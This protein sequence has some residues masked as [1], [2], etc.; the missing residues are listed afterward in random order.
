MSETLTVPLGE[1]EHLKEFFEVLNDQSKEQESIELSALL[2]QLNQMEKQ[3]TE[4]L[5]EL[6]TVKGQLSNIQEKGIK[7]SAMNG[8]LKLQEKVTEAK[9]QLEHIKS[10]ISNSVK[11]S[12]SLIKQHGISALN[13]TVDFIRLKKV[14]TNMR[15]N[16]NASISQTQKHVD[17]INAIGS[18]I[19]ALSE[20]TNNLG[21]VLTGKETKEL[22]QRNADKGTLAIVAKLLKRSKSMLEGMKQNVTHAI[23]MVDR[24]EQAASKSKEKKPSIRTELKEKSQKE[25]TKK[26]PVVTKKQDMSL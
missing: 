20:H 23:K 13:K 11:Q 14:L 26:A 22:T 8:V 17:K 15:G 4:V 16:L 19:H 18:E 9:N 5:D 10:D 3:Y 12:L 7:T 24:L 1:Q 6:K 21:R 2:S 25:P